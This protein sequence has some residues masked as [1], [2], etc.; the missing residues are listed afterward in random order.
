MILVC[1]YYH[2]VLFTLKRYRADIIKSL[3]FIFFSFNLDLSSAIV[4]LSIYQVQLVV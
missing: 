2:I 4:L 3:M 1:G